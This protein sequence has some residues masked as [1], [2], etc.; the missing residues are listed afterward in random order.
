[1]DITRAASH[2]TFLANLLMW[3]PAASAA[4]LSDGDAPGALLL[5]LQFSTRPNP[6]ESDVL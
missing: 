5:M 2:V 3:A 1:V 4:A 6:G